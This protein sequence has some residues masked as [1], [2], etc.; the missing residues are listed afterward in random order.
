MKR[1]TKVALVL[2]AVLILLAGAYAFAR[3]NGTRQAAE[4]TAEEQTMTETAENAAD[5]VEST[6]GSGTADAADGATADAGETDGTI[7]ADATEVIEEEPVVTTVTITAT[8][9]CTLGAM[10]LHSYA[11]SFNEYYDLYGESYFFENVRDIFEQDDFTLI[12]LECVLTDSTDR[13]EKTYNLKGKPE[14]VGIMTS[15]SVEGCSLGNN[16]TADYG[17]SSHEDTENALNGAGIV[18]GY[19]DHLGVYTTEEGITI[20]VV[21][22]NLLSASQLYEDYMESGIKQLRADGVDLV[23]ACCHWGIER[24]Y[25]PSDYQQEMAHK[26]VEW[27]ADL[28]IGNH[29]HVLQ[30]VE[31][32]QGKVIC[33]SLGNFSFGG[34]RNPSDKDTMLYQQTFVFE[35]GVLQSDI[36]ASII[37]CRLSGSDSYN[38]FSPVVA[39]GERWQNIIDEVNEY[40]SPY[41]SAQFDEGGTLKIS[42]ND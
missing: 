8:G 25:Y 3:I 5:G 31:V 10:Q 17:A 42:Q 11:G 20:G 13:V 18:F 14:Y 24:D 32:Y 21:S 9:D 15:S 39:E 19:N 37:P 27:G 38:D 12:N 2:A 33:Y 22:V 41:G 28:V 6:E 23:V 34:N 26:I 7:T 1:Q 16:H 35:D 36:D 29:P 30:G 40:S 4:T